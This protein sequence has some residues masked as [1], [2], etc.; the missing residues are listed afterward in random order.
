M[1]TCRCMNRQAGGHSLRWSAAGPILHEATSAPVWCPVPAAARR[2]RQGANRC[3]G[4]VV[5]GVVRLAP[6]VGPRQE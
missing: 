6:A 3:L 5:Q 1:G 2:S 4:S